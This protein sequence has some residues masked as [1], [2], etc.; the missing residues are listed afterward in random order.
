MSFKSIRTNYTKLL[1]AFESAGVKLNESQKAELDTFI[2]ALESKIQNMKEATIKATKK[3][4]TEHLDNEYK[5]VVES[6]LAN[7][8]KNEVLAGKIQA[9]IN[10]I[11]ESKK[12]ARKVD[13][14]LKMYVESSLPEKMIVDYDRMQK[15]EKLHES[16]KDLMVVNE[17]SVEAKK[18]ELQESFKKQQRDYETRIAK[19]QVKL[20][21]SMKKELELN[22]Q[23]DKTKARELLESKIK[24]LP[25]FEANQMRK[26]LSEATVAE[27]QKKFSTILESVKN[28]IKEDDKQEETSLEEEISN[29]IETDEKKEK[30]VDEKEV[31]EDD[32]LKG[33]VHNG[34]L[35]E[36]DEESVDEAD[37]LD[38]DDDVELDESEKIDASQMSWWCDMVGNI[39]TRGY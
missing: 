27:V 38:E 25:D 4:V 9:K 31:G 18:E 28:E 34:H 33:R 3:V 14:Y 36:D 30:K 11:N 35:T 12:I 17:D 19:L 8:A 39:E 22:K 6:I 2:V 16:L 23:I 37:E 7:K 5:K 20:N 13:N 21:E 15:L 26:R 24:N 1:S 29:I 32:V 10:T